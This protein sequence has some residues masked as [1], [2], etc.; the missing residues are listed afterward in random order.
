M[1]YSRK[2]FL[3]FV[4]LLPLLYLLILLRLVQIQFFD[5]TLY[6]QKAKE[7]HERR[8]PSFPKRG[9]IVDRNGFP[10][11]FD[12]PRYSIFYFRKGD[13]APNKELMKI[14][15]LLNIDVEKFFQTL[16]KRKF[17]YL[18]RG[19]D[20]N[21]VE[22]VKKFRIEGLGWEEMYIRY[23][24][25][26]ELFASVLGFVGRERK[27]LR[28]LEYYY[29][30]Y[31][32]GEKGIAH[33]MRDGKGR[34]L[35]S[36][37]YF[38]KPPRP[39]YKLVLTLDQ[40]IQY[41][42]MEE[43]TKTHRFYHAKRSVGLMLN[44]Q[45]GEILAMVS[46]PT[47]DPLRFWEHKPS[48][49]KNLAIEFVYEPGSTFKV[50]TMAAALEE[51]VVRPEEKIFCEWGAFSLYGHVIHDHEKFGWLTVGDALVYSS[52]IGLTKIGMRVGEKRLYSY[53]RRFGFGAPTG[54]DLPGEE[55]G[56]LRPVAQWSKISIGAIPY[57]QE[58]GVTPLQLAVAVSS[59]INGG[60]LLKPFVVKRIED[61][62][63]RIV[64]ERK[65]QVVRR[66][67]SPRTSSLI[68]EMMVQV[69][70]RGTGVRAKIK[71]YRVGGKTGTA[72]KYVPGK[73]YNSGK[74]V[75]SFIGFLPAQKPKFL[76]LIVVDE[77]QGGHYGGEIA[78][79]CFR[80]V[81]ERVLCYWEP[82]PKNIELAKK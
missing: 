68:R 17:V 72:Q 10:L 7:L 6:Q 35:P 63:G 74:Y 55:K 58:I 44:P 75:A 48:L 67:I 5:R 36:S 80:R 79:P 25:Q 34:L 49:Y 69:V 32:K 66:V 31:L 39:G 47:F 73:G 24:P 20:E 15:S 21:A 78:A 13:K 9:E 12:I 54:I 18:V 19:V 23:Y 59:A 45:T 64:L 4:V 11:A 22:L 40:R 81:M 76:L 26:R 61:E 3:I 8:Y 53:I 60:K 56:I 65:P 46:L 14:A 71:G 27:G 50:I 37:K 33:A 70:E 82:I 52:N 51:K 77:P 2:R 57:G 41:I 29:E 62:R 30:Q 43:L 42:L 16:Q 1:I 38:I 28:G